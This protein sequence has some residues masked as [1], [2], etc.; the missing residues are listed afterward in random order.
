MRSLPR[1]DYRSS[2]DLPKS[3]SGSRQA[4][5]P[6]RTF[7]TTTMLHLAN[8]AKRAIKPDRRSGL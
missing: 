2:V 8:K 6:D 5:D 1:S 7:D 3:V 4:L